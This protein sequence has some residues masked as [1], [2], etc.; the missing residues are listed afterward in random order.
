MEVEALKKTIILSCVLA[1]LSGCATPTIDTSTDQSMKESV[2]RVRSSLPEDKRQDFDNAL[3]ELAL[4]DL[5]LQDLMAQGTN[6]NADALT[7]KMKQRLNGQTGVQILAAAA[8]LREERDR[9]QREQAIGEIAELQKKAAE[10]AVAKQKLAAFTV[11]RSRYYKENSMF[12]TESVIEL[13]V[14]NGTDTPISRAYFHGVVASPGRS[15][16]WISEDFNYSIR[17]G[18]EPGESATWKLNPNMFSAWATDVPSDAVLTVEV[19]KLDGPDGKTLY[20][21]EGLDETEQQRLQELQK[22]YPVK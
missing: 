14:T 5:N 15:V 1:A 2:E 13:S 20:D 17:G 9:K 21:A 11:S 6:S 19:V 4:A 10:A 7:S 8:T 22:K 16:P 18:L 12:T 3:R